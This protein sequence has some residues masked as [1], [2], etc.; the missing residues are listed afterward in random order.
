MPLYGADLVLKAKSAKMP[1]EKILSAQNGLILG[2]AAM[3]ILMFVITL[4]GVTRMEA[5]QK[6]LDIIVNKYM[7]KVS[8]GTEMR[9]IAR[10]RTLLLYRIIDNPDPF[11]R[12]QYEIELLGYAGRFAN[13]RLKLLDMELSEKELELLDVLKQ[14]V[15]VALPALRKVVELVNNDHIDEAHK[16]FT[17]S[18]IPAQNAVIKTLESLYAMQYHDAQQASEL[19]H[20]AFLNTRRWMY[21]LYASLL[22]LAI[23]IVYI[24][25]KR[26]RTADEDREKH[27]SIIEKANQELRMFSTEL[28]I[29]RDAA[30][31]ASKAK[32][33]FLA[34][35]SHELRTPMNAIMGYSELLLEDMEEMSKQ[36][37]ES[38]L[39]RIY[40]ASTHLLSLID[41]VLDLSK[42]EAGKMEVRAEPFK[43]HK[44]IT[45]VLQTLEPLYKDSEC[46]LHQS[47]DPNLDL[48]I[49][50]QT[51]IRQILFN[52]LSNAYKFTAKGDIFLSAQLVKEEDTDEYVR[53]SVK[54]TGIGI[55]ESQQIRIFSPFVQGDASSTRRYEGTGLGLA[56]TKSY[57]DLLHGTIEINSVPNE[58]SEFI[59]LLPLIHN[60][61]I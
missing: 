51:K 36:E 34:N 40:N 2:F 31:Q 24:V 19:A 10:E 59:V 33:Q 29:A 27:L 42:V 18:S 8:L 47:I 41:Q 61:D 37:L 12:D 44:L 60:I 57:T 43:V 17:E 45:E 5:T 13:A 15:H 32:S 16:L 6:E 3:L 28:I 49:S 46:E 4:V 23:F 20:K 7:A 21:Y 11:E 22:G 58:G 56:L 50:D 35:M 25:L 39:R 52:L 53:F 1:F 30:Q 14:Q 54:D 48:M 26:N 9:S 38:D 55:S